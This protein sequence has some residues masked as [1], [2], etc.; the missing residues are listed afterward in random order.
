MTTTSPAPAVAEE[1]CPDDRVAVAAVPGKIIVA[2][3]K[4]DAAAFAETFSVDGTM[5]LPGRYRK[6]REDIQAF[7]R[8]AFAGPYRNTK[9]TGEV[10]DVRFY[11]ADTAILTTEGGVLAPGESEVA[12]ERAIRATWVVVR[13]DGQ[14]RLA[15]YQNTPRGT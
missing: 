12:E 13:E 3:A 15:A 4:H 7:M 1:V 9:V 11:G 10:I 14:W 2:W 6:G 5:I 8:A